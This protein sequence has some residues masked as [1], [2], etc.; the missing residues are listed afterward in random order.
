MIAAK[1][2]YAPIDNVPVLAI[3]KMSTT[4]QVAI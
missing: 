1:N 4:I 2:K 3:S